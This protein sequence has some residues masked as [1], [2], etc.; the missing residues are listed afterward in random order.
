M[1]TTEG[2]E[3][4]EDTEAAND[5]GWGDGLVELDDEGAVVGGFGEGGDV[6]DMGGFGVDEGEHGLVGEGEVEA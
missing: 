5:V 1:G 4:T 3:G 2:T 6:H